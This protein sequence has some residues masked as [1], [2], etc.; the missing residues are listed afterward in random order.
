MKN[1]FLLSLRLKNQKGDL[2]YLAKALE[3]NVK[4]IWSNGDSLPKNRTADYSYCVCEIVVNEDFNLG[5]AI[6]NISTTLLRKKNDIENFTNSGGRLSLFVS[7][8]VNG[9]SGATLD[10]SQ[11]KSL[12]DLHISLDIDRLS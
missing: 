10:S 8:D 5:Q 2:S 3:L 9:F 6:E 4:K 1:D 11:L 12:G 7:L